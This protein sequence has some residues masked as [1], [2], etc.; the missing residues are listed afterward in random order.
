VQK[1]LLI[2]NLIVILLFLTACTTQKNIPSEEFF[3]VKIYLCQTNDCEA[4][5]ISF[6]E[7]AQS[8]VYCAFY[9]F[10]LLDTAKL[11]AEKSKTIDVRIVSDNSTRDDRFAA[12]NIIYNTEDHLMHNKFCVIDDK[13]IMTGSF[14][15]TYNDAKRN[16]NNMI[17]IYSPLLA[18]NYKS[19]FLEM[20]GGTFGKGEKTENNIINL[21]GIIIE[22]YFCPEDKCEDKFV[23][24]I[25]SAKKSVYFMAFTFTSNP[26]ADAL[27]FLDR[28]VTIKG[29]VE[30]QNLGNY[31]EYE[32]LNQFGIFVKKD[33]N[34]YKMHHKVFIIDNETV[35]TG[36]FNPTWSAAYSN[37]ENILII[38]DKSVA[39]AYMKEF[40][41]VYYS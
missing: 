35:I 4:G 22:N 41:R 8:Y 12:G 17:I 31:S 39:D 19:E 37:D 33:S 26:I 1:K 3:T 32:R 40:Y 9:D 6:I 14:N 34:K 36:S 24:A 28:N 23:N 5:L 13:A 21:S 27:L 29:V 2:F 7:E 30:T 25:S 16:D 15:P 11:L 10:N 38:H 18:Q 20:W